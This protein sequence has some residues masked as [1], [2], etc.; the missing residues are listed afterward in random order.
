M[1]NNQS[2]E[3]CEEV[4]DREGDRKVSM[5]SVMNS[6]TAA[7]HSISPQPPPTEP[8]LLDLTD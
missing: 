3:T 8:P 4:M 6:G 2:T 7:C 1:I 5:L